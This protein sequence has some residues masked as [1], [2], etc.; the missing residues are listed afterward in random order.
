MGLGN[1]RIMHTIN[2]LEGDIYGKIAVYYKPKNGTVNYSPSFNENS[3]S[4]HSQALQ[5][6]S[7]YQN[8]SDDLHFEQSEL[9]LIAALV[10]LIP[11]KIREEFDAK[12]LEWEKSWVRYELKPLPADYK[13]AEEYIDLLNY[14]KQYGKALYPSVIDKMIQKG[15]YLI[16]WALLEDYTYEGERFNWNFLPSD[17][18]RSYH[19]YL[20]YYCKNLLANEKD[21]ILKD[22]LHIIQITNLDIIKFENGTLAT[23]VVSV[24]NQAISIN[25]YSEKEETASVKIYNIV[26]SLEFESSYNVPKGRQTVVINASKFTKGIYIV[27]ITVGNKTQSQKISF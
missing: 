6:L 24:N 12:Y 14:C 11:A 17:Y 2:A 9:E 4:A 5:Q 15:R 27:Q 23:S 7:A 13:V 16:E 26:G 1:E 25:L 18:R 22:I 20:V 21:D 19:N 10:E 8:Y 3:I